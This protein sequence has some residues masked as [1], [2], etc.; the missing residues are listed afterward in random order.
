MSMSANLK[1]RLKRVCKRICKRTTQHSMAQATTSRDHRRRNP[2]PERT[3][4]YSAV[5][6]IT[7]II[8]LENRCTGNRTVGSNPTLSVQR[9]G[10]ARLF[11]LFQI[12]TTNCTTTKRTLGEQ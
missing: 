4:S 11:W 5:R 6:D 8:E 1:I 9:Q 12:C 10:N 7:R 2:E 3:V